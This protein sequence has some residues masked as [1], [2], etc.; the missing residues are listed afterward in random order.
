HRLR[1]YPCD[2]EQIVFYGKTSPD[3][4][5]LILV[6]VNLDPHHRQT[7]WVRVPLAELGLAPGESYQVHDLITEAR[8]LWHGESNYV[9]LDPSMS[10]AHILRLR[11]RVKTERDFD[12]YF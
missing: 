2:N 1:F 6:V 4:D 7:G 10:A 12:Y 5:N 11:K 9:D 3:L 8:F